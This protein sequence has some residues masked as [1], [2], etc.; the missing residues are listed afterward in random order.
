MEPL[1]L[2]VTH[3]LYIPFYS[4]FFF[5]MLSPLGFLRN[6][7]DR[8]RADR[9]A[10]KRE[11]VA[12][13]LLRRRR[14]GAVEGA[15]LSSDTFVIRGRATEANMMKAVAEKIRRDRDPVEKKFLRIRNALVK[16]IIRAYPGFSK[17]EFLEEMGMSM[18]TSEE[19]SG[20]PGMNDDS[21]DLLGQDL[22]QRAHADHERRLN[23][24]FGNFGKGGG[25][26]NK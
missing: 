1:T 13:D 2:K 6:E 5:F 22:A 26:E 20:L 17:K 19:I 24:I 15:P 16:E 7:F 18:L 25:F 23:N 14:N 12:A 8:R 10:C 3:T 9:E 11:D 21:L 4:H